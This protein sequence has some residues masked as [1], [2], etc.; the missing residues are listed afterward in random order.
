MD[1]HRSSLRDYILIGL[2]F[3]FS[4]VMTLCFADIY[5]SQFCVSCT[6]TMDSIASCHRHLPPVFFCVVESSGSERHFCES[7]ITHYDT[8]ILRLQSTVGSP[9]GYAASAEASADFVVCTRYPNRKNRRGRLFTRNG[10]LL[11][12]PSHLAEKILKILSAIHLQICGFFDGDGSCV[13]SVSANALPCLPFT[14]AWHA[15]VIA[16]KEK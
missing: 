2:G 16:P 15:P 6:C 1:V 11:I 7:V 12:S 13:G 5:I 10:G 8:F 9:R 3:L 14:G 4:F